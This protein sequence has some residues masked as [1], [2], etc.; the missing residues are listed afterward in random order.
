MSIGKKMEEALNRQIN[1]ELY[2]S[3]IYLSMS[4]YFDAANLKG[5]A[6]WMLVQSG[7]ETEHAMRFYRYL[8]D[9]GARV[10]FFEI[11]EPQAEWESPLNA[12]EE[13]HK[14]EEY[15]TGKINWLVELADAEKDNETAKMLQWFVKEQVEEE[16]STEAV[17]QKLRLAKDSADALTR[18]D[19]ELGK[20]KAGG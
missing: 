8:V 10:K 20:R 3:Y 19:S 4:A 16:A 1:E 11:K 17:V 6:N 7:E 12:F 15:I 2:S 13:A 14:H 18:I 5:L 9:K